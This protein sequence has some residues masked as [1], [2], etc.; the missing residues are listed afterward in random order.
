MK[1]LRCV[2]CATLALTEEMALEN[3]MFRHGD[4]CNRYYGCFICI[5][6]GCCRVWRAGL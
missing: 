1:I 3:C 5:L 2:N 4:A 6:S